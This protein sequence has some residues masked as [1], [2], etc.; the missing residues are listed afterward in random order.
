MRIQF[1]QSQLCGCS[2]FSRSLSMISNTAGACWMLTACKLVRPWSGESRSPSLQ[3][4]RPCHNDDQIQG[5]IDELARIARCVAAFLLPAQLIH[6]VDV[7]L[8]QEHRYANW[9][10][11]AFSSQRVPRHKQR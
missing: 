3:Q 2:H 1:W 11:K 9:D 5:G 10:D 4:F 7:A 6:S 8:Y